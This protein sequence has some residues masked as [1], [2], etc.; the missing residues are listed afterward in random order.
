ML[1]SAASYLAL[2]V[3]CHELLASWMPQKPADRLP[4]CFAVLFEVALSCIPEG[5]CPI[6]PGDGQ[7]LPVWVPS[8]AYCRG[9]SDIL[10]TTFCVSPCCAL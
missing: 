7:Q 9:A 2:R 3:C 10:D 8:K 6:L 1:A 4:V 5:H